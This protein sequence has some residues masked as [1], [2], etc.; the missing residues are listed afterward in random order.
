METERFQYKGE[1]VST[2]YIPATAAQ[3]LQVG[4]NMD[5]YQYIGEKLKWVTYAKLLKKEAG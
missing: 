1:R 5:Y 2:Y 4:L 3:L